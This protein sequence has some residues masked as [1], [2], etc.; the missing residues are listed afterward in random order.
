MAALDDGRDPATRRCSR[1]RGFTLL[2]LLMTLGVT[3]VGLVGL[4]ALHF[5]VAHGND[6]ASR[7]ADAAQVANSTLESLR[8][9]RLTDMAATLTAN[10]AALPPMD[11]NPANQIVRGMTYRRRVVVTQAAV[12][13]WLIRVE[14]GWTEDGAAQGAN[15]G[16]YDHLFAVE[17]LRPIVGDL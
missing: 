5:S 4:M 10:P 8:A 2:E 17:V 11:V 3:T 15:A 9:L 14:V 1:E 7:S 6:S 12:G 16:A 13:L